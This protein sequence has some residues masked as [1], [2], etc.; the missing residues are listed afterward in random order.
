V[1]AAVGLLLLLLATYVPDV[2]RS[3]LDSGIDAFTSIAPDAYAKQT[4][5]FR[6]WEDS[7]SPD[8]I[9]VYQNV[10]MYQIENAE[11]ILAG[12]KPRVTEH[13]PYVY[14]EFK[15]KFDISYTSDPDNRELVQ[16]REWIYWEYQWEMSGAG[17][18]PFSDTYTMLN[19]PFLA[20]TSVLNNTVTPDNPAYLGNDGMLAVAVLCPDYKTDLARLFINATVN[21]M[22]FG[23]QT[24]ITKLIPQSGLSP[25]GYFP[26][27][28]G[29]NYGPANKTQAQVAVDTPFDQMYTG[30]DDQD[31]ARQYYSWKET[32]YLNISLG[33]L[34][35][36][37]FPIWNSAVANRVYGT[38]GLKWGKG[39]KEGATVTAWVDEMSRHTPL[40]NKDN[41][42]VKV[43]GIDLLRFVLDPTMLLNATHVP[44][45][46]DYY[47]TRFNGL[48]DVSISKQTLAIFMSKPHFLDADQELLDDVQGLTPPVRE[49]HDTMVDVEPISGVTMQAAKRLQVNYKLEPWVINGTNGNYYNW[50]PR[51]G[52]GALGLR[53][54]PVGWVDEFATITSSKA[55]DFRAKVYA[56]QGA[57]RYLPLLGG[58]FGA[59]A[60]AAA[61]HMLIVAK[62]RARDEAEFHHAAHHLNEY[63]H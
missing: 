44:R 41:L 24:C 60:V 22:L 18:N 14:R 31:Y 12:A 46:A 53:M 55:S 33:V 21:D 39:I 57:I 47:A 59:I 5:G 42:H 26:G 9:P 51:T 35:Q 62:G 20:V 10:W 17:L 4:E 40:I 52:D 11:E 61:L 13:G 6:T 29:P 3:K 36:E 15:R 7:A 8:A 50:Y 32:N 56:A 34:V 58:I 25:A 23:F 1:V 38:A 37:T 19:L 27:L 45:N 54:I 30:S 63:G 49:L 2:I 43:H 28:L 16:F 48:Q